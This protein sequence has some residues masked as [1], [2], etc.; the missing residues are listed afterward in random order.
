MGGTS[1]SLIIESDNFSLDAVEVFLALAAIY[2]VT[3][4]TSSGVHICPTRED[5]ELTNWTTVP[6]YSAIIADV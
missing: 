4:E 6:L 1:D 2:A 3:E 5:D